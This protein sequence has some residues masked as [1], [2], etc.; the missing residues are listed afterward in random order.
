M[1]R[2]TLGLGLTATLAVALVAACSSGAGGGGGNAAGMTGSGGAGSEGSTAGTSP[3]GMAGQGQGGSGA[4][5]GAG[6]SGAEGGSTTVTPG[7][8]GASCTQNSDCGGANAECITKEQGWP[9][10][11]CTN[12]CSDTQPCPNGS[13]CFK[14]T[15]DSTYCLKT[16]ASK[17]ECPGGYACYSVGACAPACID[18][19]ECD[20]GEVCNKQSG[21]CEAAPCTAT[22]CGSGL[23]C[24][25]ASGK[26]VPDSGSAPPPGPGP[27]CTAKLPQRDCT[28]TA[29]YCNELLP[30]EP[31]LGP[32][33][34]DYPLNG[35]T[36]TNQ[37]RSYL[38]RDAQM[39]V[40]YAS[41]YVECKAAGWNTGN[42]GLIGLGDM[43]EA[44]G[45]IPGTSVGQPGHPAG[46]HVDG[47]DI[48][49]GYFQAGTVDNKLRPICPHTSGGKDQYHC[50][51]PPDKLD[52][53]R[54][55]LFL[56]ALMTSKDVR[57]IGVDGQVGTLVEAAASTLAST[58]WLPSSVA[59][60][61]KLAFEVTNTG[62]GW[63]QF[64]HHHLH[65]S[66]WK[67]TP[68]GIAPDFGL[69]AGQSLDADL[70]PF[71]KIP[72]HGMISAT[73]VKRIDLQLR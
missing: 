30:F 61:P 28:G 10:G 3:G 62:A 51:A 49:I 32:G 5:A 15:D 43:S 19:S 64:H 60:L 18:D 48:D 8:V 45:A 37:Y 22:S 31:D 68:S 29:T 40:K 47:V 36:Q 56:G 39:L 42:G 67:T 13:E 57:V 63:Y 44:N 52:V 16:C 17:S 1:M 14:F 72:G 38:R 53:W 59:S 6:G 54:T 12:A 73:P 50:V 41:A 34:E 58:G 21:L 55:A 66:T 24:D 20:S 2:K 46:T 65:L 25:T 9:N 69:G 35:E 4:E 33:Y 7:E 23:K 26:C 71:A 27:D 11:Y 70:L